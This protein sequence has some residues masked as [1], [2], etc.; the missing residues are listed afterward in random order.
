MHT[1]IE[2]GVLKPSRL[3]PSP[4]PVLNRMHQG[5]SS[6]LGGCAESDCGDP[7]PPPVCC[8][9]Q[10]RF[11]STVSETQPTRAM[12]VSSLSGVCSHNSGQH[13]LDC[14]LQ[15]VYRINMKRALIE[16]TGIPE[17]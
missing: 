16:V 17:T 4:P 7:P 15:L 2:L 12:A 14:K 9:E 10:N 13:V 5:L 6:S 3:Q 11:S 1:V 8:R